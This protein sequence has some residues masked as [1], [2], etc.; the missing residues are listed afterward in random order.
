MD[1][2]VLWLE[3]GD[4]QLWRSGR[5]AI[6]WCRCSAMVTAGFEGVDVVPLRTQKLVF[7]I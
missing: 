7:S 6:T 3:G 4:N 1:K 2:K 5:A